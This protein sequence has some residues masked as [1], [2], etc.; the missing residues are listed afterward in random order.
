MFD[1]LIYH[2]TNENKSQRIWVRFNGL[3]STLIYATSF[4]SPCW[5]KSYNINENNRFLSIKISIMLWKIQY[6]S[7][8]GQEKKSPSPEKYCNIFVF[9]YRP[10]STFCF[11]YWH[12]IIFSCIWKQ[13]YV[14]D[15]NEYMKL[16]WVLNPIHCHDLLFDWFLWYLWSESPLKLYFKAIIRRFY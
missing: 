12:S 9:S 7:L 6:S 3:Y 4:K 8:H 2:L 14:V 16:L 13:V 11:F 1:Y 10:Q 15:Y 5:L